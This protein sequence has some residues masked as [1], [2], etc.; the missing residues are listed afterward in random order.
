MPVA[1]NVSYL[2]RTFELPPASVTI[3]SSNGTALFSSARVDAPLTRRTFSAVPIGAWKCWAG[4]LAAL[5]DPAAARAQTPGA[6][7]LVHR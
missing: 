4:E 5:A 1:Y 3:V 2:H 6:P 7:P